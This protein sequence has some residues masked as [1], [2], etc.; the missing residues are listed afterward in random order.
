MLSE[1]QVKE[2]D[3]NGCL[4]GGK[5]IGD[6]TVQELRDELDRVIAKGQNGFAEGEARP[7]LISNLSGKADAPVWQIVN[8]WEA[9]PAFERLLYTR[10]VIEAI[11]QLTHQPDIQIWHDQIQF[12]PPKH[13]G[14][15]N[16]HQVAP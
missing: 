10:P 3:R 9:S 12:K 14:V 5:V 15:N 6:D 8:I 7:V 13:G 1:Q 11:S 2:F 16:W 4:I